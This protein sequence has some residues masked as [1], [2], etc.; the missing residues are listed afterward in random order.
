M[1]AFDDLVRDIAQLRA[2]RGQPAATGTASPMRKA[3]ARRPTARLVLTAAGAREA[4]A[5]IARSG[6]DRQ[7]TTASRLM[8]SMT[9]SGRLTGLAACEAEARLHH[10]QNLRAGIR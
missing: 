10:L 5:H 3:L 9:A 8:K 6:L 2:D 1:S 4:G 7:I